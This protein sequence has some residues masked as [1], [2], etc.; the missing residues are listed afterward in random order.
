MNMIDVIEYIFRYSILTKMST[1][2]RQL[3]KAF[4][5]LRLVFILPGLKGCRDLFFLEVVNLKEGINQII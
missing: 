2:T 4:C 1:I 5:S 3:Q